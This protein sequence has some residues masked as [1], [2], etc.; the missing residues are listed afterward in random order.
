MNLQKLLEGISYVVLQSQVSIDEI[1]IHS[2][3][4]DSKLIEPKDVFVC[5]EGTRIDGHDY[6]EDAYE[7]GAS[8]CDRKTA[9]GTP[10]DKI[11]G[12]DD[13]NSCYRYKNYL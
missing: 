5:I 3:S 12:N 7:K 11:S 1:E 10:E 2:L 4:C 13:C 6:I 9:K 8:V